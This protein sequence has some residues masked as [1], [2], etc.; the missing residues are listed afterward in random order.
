MIFEIAISDEKTAIK[1]VDLA[2]VAAAQAAS[3]NNSMASDIVFR[4]PIRGLGNNNRFRYL[5]AR[6]KVLEL[7]SPYFKTSMCA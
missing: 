4:F 3:F 5:F 7:R 6:K 2:V 1:G